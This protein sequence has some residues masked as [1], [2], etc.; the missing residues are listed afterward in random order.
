MVHAAF[1]KAGVQKQGQ[2]DEALNVREIPS[3]K[4]LEHLYKP[5]G[6]NKTSLQKNQHSTQ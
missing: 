2:I 4:A 6:I 3:T 1:L 5:T